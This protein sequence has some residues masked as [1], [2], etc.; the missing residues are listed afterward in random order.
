MMQK[1]E[2]WTAVDGSFGEIKGGKGRQSFLFECLFYVSCFQFPF[3]EYH[4]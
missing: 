1:I 4:T 3:G 2:I